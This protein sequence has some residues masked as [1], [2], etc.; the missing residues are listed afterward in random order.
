MSLLDRRH[1]GDDV[2]LQQ[3]RSIRDE[4]LARDGSLVADDAAELTH[5]HDCGGRGLVPPV[6]MPQH[7][8]R[9]QCRLVRNPDP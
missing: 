6:T 5:A 3:R 4:L 9:L 7:V 2:V 1:A 8:E